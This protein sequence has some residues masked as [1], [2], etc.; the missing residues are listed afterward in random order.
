MYEEFH[1][2][3]TGGDVVDVDIELRVESGEWMVDGGMGVR[4]CVVLW[5]GVVGCVVGC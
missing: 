1:R 4:C 3:T 2:L 5:C